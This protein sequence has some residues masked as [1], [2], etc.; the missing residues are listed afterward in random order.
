MHGKIH[1]HNNFTIYYL[2]P[3]ATTLQIMELAMGHS[4]VTPK[5][6]THYTNAY[7]N[8]N[9]LYSYQANA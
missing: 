5:H 8:T 4:M 7:P 2:T 1:A 3:L 6:I 9:F